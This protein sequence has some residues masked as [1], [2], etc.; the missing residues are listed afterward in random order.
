MITLHLWPIV[1]CFF[2]TVPD[3]I[4]LDWVVS[5]LYRESNRRMSYD[6]MWF[7]NL[8]PIPQNVISQYIRRNPITL[9]SNFDWKKKY[10]KRTSLPLWLQKFSP[11]CNTD[12]HILKPYKYN[13]LY[14]NTY[15]SIYYFL[16]IWK[17]FYYIVFTY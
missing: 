6:E 13:K 1:L 11:N 15:N 8:M 16:P 5:I 14:N 10:Q 17:S 12:I 9:T 3:L 7:K 4:Q 2:I